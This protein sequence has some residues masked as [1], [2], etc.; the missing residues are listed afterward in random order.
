MPHGGAARRLAQDGANL[1]GRAAGLLE[2][3]QARQAVEVGA[4]IG[5]CRLQ[6]RGRFPTAGGAAA[7]GLGAGSTRET[8]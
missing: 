1:V 8:P 2:C 3:L 7:C 4:A 5:N 6:S